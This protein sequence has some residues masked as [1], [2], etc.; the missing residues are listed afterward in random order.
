MEE[1]HGVA[2]FWIRSGWLKFIVKNRGIPVVRQMSD[3]VS[4]NRRVPLPPGSAELG[5]YT[6]DETAFIVMVAVPSVI[7]EGWMG[8]W[9]LF[10]ASKDVSEASLR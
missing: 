9:L 5:N 1:V 8:P 3:R 6:D 10:G 4:P 2:L 7:A